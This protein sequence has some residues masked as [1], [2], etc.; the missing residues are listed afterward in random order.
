MEKFVKGKCNISRERLYQNINQG[1]LGLIDI[2]AFIN[3][4]QV[5]WIKRLLAEASDNWREDVWNIIYGNPLILHPNLVNKEMH[6]IIFSIAESFVVFKKTFFE[7][8][9]NYKKMPIVFN[10]LLNPTP[11][12]V[13]PFDLSLF[14][15]I[16]E[17]R[18]EIIAR[19]KF[20]DIHGG[21]ALNLN[22]INAN[23][24]LNLNLTFLSYLRISG[25]CRNF[26]A[27]LKNSRD[28]NNTSIEMGDFFTK[29]FNDL[30]LSEEGRK[31]F[32][33]GILPAGLPDGKLYSVT[34]LL[35]QY[36]FWS[37]KLKNKKPSPF[38]IEYDTFSILAAIS[39]LNKK[40]CKNDHNFYFSRR[41]STVLHEHGL[42]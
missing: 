33:F 31:R 41:F 29:F 8:N 5:L 32:W 37:A 42:H 35:I 19:V 21:V 1:G 6:P 11:G 25:A 28:T 16:P 3:S 34:I 7:L 20:N 30:N 26:V 14:R 24:D 4:Q 36:G 15:Q 10:P 13:R 22:T 27:N 17:I 40:I 39:K 2:S 18:P 38:K 23:P 12:D 9:D